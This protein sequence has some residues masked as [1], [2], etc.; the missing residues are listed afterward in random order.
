MATPG[1]VIEHPNRETSSS[2]VTKAVIVVLLVASAV[3]TA[4]ITVGGWSVLE[5]ATALQIAYIVLYL[6]IAYFVARWKRGLLPVAAA[7][8]IILLIFAAVSGPQWLDRDKPGFTDPAMSAGILGL[9][10]LLLVPLQVLLIAASLRG[11]RQRWNIEVERP[12]DDPGG[13]DAR[14]RRRPRRDAAPA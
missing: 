14:G 2:K 12:A 3:L 9:L 8:A 11:F 6:V 4:V 5:G 7:L 10:T 1:Y 13:D